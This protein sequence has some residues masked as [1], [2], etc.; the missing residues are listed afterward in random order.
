M[1]RAWTP[2][3]ALHTLMDGYNNAYPRVSRGDWLGTAKKQ[4]CEP[5]RSLSDRVGVSSP[6]KKTSVGNTVQK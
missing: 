3:S 1:A 6:W 4:L 5:E 2:E